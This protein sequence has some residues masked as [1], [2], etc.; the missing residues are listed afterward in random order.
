MQSL[1]YFHLGFQMMFYFGE[2]A[3]RNQRSISARGSGL[4]T[5]THLAARSLHPS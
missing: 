4:N 1:Q 2:E 5:Q 3:K